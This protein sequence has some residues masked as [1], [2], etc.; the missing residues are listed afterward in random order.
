MLKPFTFFIQYVIILMKGK[1]EQILE[2]FMSKTTYA[3]LKEMKRTYSYKVINKGHGVYTFVL[4][5]RIYK[6]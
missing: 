4:V 3:I 5:T 2:G 1:K 6:K